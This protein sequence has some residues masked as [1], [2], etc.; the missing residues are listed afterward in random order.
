MFSEET[1]GHY[2]ARGLCAIALPETCNATFILR[3]VPQ[4]LSK[5]QA[6]V[7]FIGN[8]DNEA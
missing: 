7:S 6:Y 2:V 3:H 8:D 5:P 1:E 4:R